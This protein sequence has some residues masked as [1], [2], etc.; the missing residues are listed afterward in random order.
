MEARVAFK[1]QY[2]QAVDFFLSKRIM[3]RAEFDQLAAA[4]KATAF[5]AARVTTAD[6]LQT[7]YDEVGRALQQGTTLADFKKDTAGILDNAWH[8]ET[9]FRTN[10][11]GAYGLGHWEQAQ[12]VKAMRPYVRYSAVADMRTRPWHMELQGLV[13][14]LDDPFVVEH[15]CPWEY[16]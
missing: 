7:V 11:M 15:W 5:T 2:G 16:N 8:R 1:R 3:P 12:A 13:F 14:H 10:V 9:V 6:S 4:E